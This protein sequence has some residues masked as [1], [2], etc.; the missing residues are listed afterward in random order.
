MKKCPF[1]E[2]EIQDEA[3]VC[4]HCGRNLSSEKIELK[5]ENDS[6]IEGKKEKKKSNSIWII[7]VIGFLLLI[8]APCLLCRS[9][10]DLFSSLPDEPSA[11]IKPPIEPTEAII[12]PPIYEIFGSADG[13]M[14]EAQLDNYM[15]GLKGNLVEDWQGNVVDV[16]ENLVLGGYVVYVN[17]VETKYWKDVRILVNEEVALSLNK[18]QHIVFNGVISD[19]DLTEF[20]GM[21]VF[22][23]NATINTESGAD[24]PTPY[25]RY[26]PE[27]DGILDTIL[28][29]MSP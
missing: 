2:E 16:E 17:M 15:K 21:Y 12:A 4:K 20:Q 24:L 27:T 7:L 9:S 13:S 6:P 14:T 25:P 1:C 11:T 23:R 26:T 29:F 5:S 19:V 10:N 28:D 22:I 8:G 18:D 3:I